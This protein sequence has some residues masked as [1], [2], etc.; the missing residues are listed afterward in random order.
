MVDSLY[1]IIVYTFYTLLVSITAV[2]AHQL[3]L[4]LGIESAT[5]DRTVLYMIISYL[6]IQ[7]MDRKV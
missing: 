5:L 7:K 4:W 2:V 6:I 3:A 1:F